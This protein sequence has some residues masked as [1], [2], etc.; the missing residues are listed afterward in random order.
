MNSHSALALTT[1]EGVDGEGQT[2]TTILDIPG[3]HF[4]TKLCDGEEQCDSDTASIAAQRA[5]F[6]NLTQKSRSTI[7]ITTCRESSTSS[8]SRVGPKRYD[9]YGK[10]EVGST[11]AYNYLNA[12]IGDCEYRG[13]WPG[14]I[15]EYWGQD[16]HTAN[17]DLRLQRSTFISDCTTTLKEVCSKLDTEASP[18]ACIKK[19]VERRS[20]AEAIG[21]AWANT[22]L[23]MSILFA[24]LGAL[25]ATK[26]RGPPTGRML[27]PK[28]KDPTPGSEHVRKFGS[29][30]RTHASL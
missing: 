11:G 24:L 18:F 27:P 28:V 20:F 14:D 21:T 6:A 7:A 25:L 3:I 5:L 1:F 12:K 23:G 26:S 16:C 17:V 29:E 22:Q 8:S 15:G 13:T 4:G 19:N 10:G 2:P 9:C 30:Y